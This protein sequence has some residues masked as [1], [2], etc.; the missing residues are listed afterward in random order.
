MVVIVS[1]GT[2]TL[3]QSVRVAIQNSS[4]RAAIERLA[5]PASGSSGLAV[6]G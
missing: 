4:A 1:P 5:A 6:P 2:P 3:C